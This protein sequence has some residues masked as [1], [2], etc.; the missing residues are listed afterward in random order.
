MAKQVNANPVGSG[1]YKWTEFAAGD[2]CVFEARTDYWKQEVPID[3]IMFHFY[4]SA[5]AQ[6][7]ALQNGDIDAAADL[8][9]TSAVPQLLRDPNMGISFSE[10]QYTTRLDL[11]LRMAP[12][13]ILEFRQALNVLFDRTS[14]CN[15]SYAG[16][17]IIPQQIP[18]APIMKEA[19]A[20]LKWPYVAKTQAERAAMANEILD[21]IPGMSAKPATPASGWVRTYNGTPC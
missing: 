14:I 17:G 7:L 6:L 20:S 5:D 16:Y 8:E 11:N 3:T 15:N 10:L 18:F 2:S 9:I 4:G 21:K 12:F 1:P 13:N 19:V